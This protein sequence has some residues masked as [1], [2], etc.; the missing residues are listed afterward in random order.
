[1]SNQD[2][3]KSIG[4][5]ALSATQPAH[6]AQDEPVLSYFKDEDCVKFGCTKKLPRTGNSWGRLYVS[7]TQ[8][9]QGEP[10]DQ[11]P[12]L[13]KP[14]TVG[15]GTFG[16]G[17]SARLVVEAA[18]RRHELNQEQSKLTP[19][20]AREQELNRR[21]A[22][23]MLNGPAQPAV[24]QGAGEVVPEVPNLLAEARG[25]AYDEEGHIM[26]PDL[27]SAV[28]NIDAMLT[29]YPT[30]PAQLTQVVQPVSRDVIRD[31]FLRNGFTIKPGC[32]DLKPYVYEAANALLEVAAI[33]ASGRQ[34]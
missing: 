17:V 34:E 10:T 3:Q 20:Q 21:K 23:D 9:A 7:A 5:A 18:Q 24:A 11:W 28:E 26:D 2:I 4:R 32:G 13:N 6:G 31:V 15:A 22:W 27:A 16:V 29:S 14:A 25:A 30:P 19:E 8:A 1:M 33:A 12:K